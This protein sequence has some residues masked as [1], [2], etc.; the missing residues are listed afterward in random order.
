M[1]IG[2]RFQRSNLSIKT[3]ALE[4][5]Q[6]GFAVCLPVCWHYFRSHL[7]AARRFYNHYRCARERRAG[8]AL[9][10]A[11]NRRDDPT[12]RCG[13][14]KEASALRRLG[15]GQSTSHRHGLTFSRAFPTGYCGSGAAPMVRVRTVLPRHPSITE[16]SSIHFARAIYAWRIM[17]ARN[18]FTTSNGFFSPTEVSVIFGAF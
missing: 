18:R 11:A 7:V 4:P 3:Q 12:Y 6:E 10:S 8:Y 5:R 17:K 9:R 2:Q 13:A 16:T 1:S 15:K 14:W